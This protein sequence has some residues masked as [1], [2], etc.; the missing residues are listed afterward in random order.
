MAKAA[1]KSKKISAK[2][3]P[4]A[5][6][7]AKRAPAASARKALAKTPAKTAASKAPKPAA[8]ERV[9]VCG[10]RILEGPLEVP[11]AWIARCEDPQGAMF[12]LMGPRFAKP[13]GYFERTEPNDQADPRGRRWSW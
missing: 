6:S 4:S 12:A 13:V 10:G 8:A 5:A 7:R 9:K 1:A 2:S 11:G 3:K